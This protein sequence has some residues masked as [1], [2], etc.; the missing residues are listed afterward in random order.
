MLK[1][2][3]VYFLSISHDTRP[4]PAYVE[5][6]EALT[7]SR[8]GICRSPSLHVLLGIKK[9]TIKKRHKKQFCLKKKGK[10]HLRGNR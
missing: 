9:L 2:S 4:K 3:Q 7:K 5:E 6:R 1:R 8:S 10:K